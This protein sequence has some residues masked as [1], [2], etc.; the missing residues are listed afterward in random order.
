MAYLVDGNNF[1][2]HCSD[3]GIRTPEAKH[4]LILR[5]LAFQQFTR[6]RVYL[7]FDGRESADFPDEEFKKDKFTVLHPEPG[8]TADSI[9]KDMIDRRHDRRHLIL[10]SSDRELKEFARERGAGVVGCREFERELK[11]VLRERK[12]EVELRKRTA[13]LT[14]L[15]VRLWQDAFGRKK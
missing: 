3:R 10:V 6:S 7:V 12:K 9:L 1:L 8:L 11:D 5:L 2:G 4:G 13:R 14:P 15:E